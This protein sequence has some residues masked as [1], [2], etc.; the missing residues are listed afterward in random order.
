MNEIGIRKRNRIVLLIL[1]FVFVTL[2]SL[3]IM[4]LV[5]RSMSVPFQDIID[6]ITNQPLLD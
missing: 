3:S 4:G 1:C 6:I 2:F 5:Y